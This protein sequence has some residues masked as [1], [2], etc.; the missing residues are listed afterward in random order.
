MVEEGRRKK[1]Q[2]KGTKVEAP[3]LNH[4]DEH[5]AAR[6]RVELIAVHFVAKYLVTACPNFPVELIKHSYP[7]SNQIAPMVDKLI[8]FPAATVPAPVDDEEL[9]L[10]A[11][12]AV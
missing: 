4:V 7:K 11:A 5:H 12:A 10:A 1:E 9:L 2:G 3:N 6:H 8:P